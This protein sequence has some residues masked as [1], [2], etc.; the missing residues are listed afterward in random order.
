MEDWGRIGTGK[1]GEKRKKTPCLKQNLNERETSRRDADVN[2]GESRE[3]EK[4]EKKRG[5]PSTNTGL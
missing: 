3:T 2:N 5:K 4:K 1:R